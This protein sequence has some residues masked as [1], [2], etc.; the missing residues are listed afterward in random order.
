MTAATARRLA[1]CA[2]LASSLIAATAAAEPYLAVREGVLCSQCHVNRTGGGKRTA[3]G[4]IY[5]QTVMPHYKITVPEK[6]DGEEREPRGF[7]FD[8]HWGE[9]VSFGADLR[10][11]NLTTFAATTTWNDKPQTAPAGNTFKIPV[12][13]LFVEASL[14]KEHLVVYVDET[15]GPEGAALREGFAMYRELPLHGYVKAGRFLLPYGLRF[16]DDATFVRDM[17]GFNYANQD[18]GV[19]IGAEPGAAFVHVSLTNGTQG[20][21]DT[22]ISKQVTATA[23]ALFRP[24][25]F[26][27]LYSYADGSTDKSSTVRHV[28]GAYAALG[29]GRLAILGEADLMR[30]YSGPGPASPP[31]SLPGKVTW[32]LAAY[33]EVDLLVYRG[34]NVRVAYDYQDPFFTLASNGQRSRLTVGTEVFPIP[35]LG[36][37]VFYYMRRDVPQHVTENQDQLIVQIHGFL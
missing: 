31:G 33:G 25:R 15:V 17:T 34:V 29:I 8:P 32:Q 16:P 26:A 24:F 10:F 3:F 1:A 14:F 12:A 11:Q 35:F 27:L 4:V 7:F 22:N 20:G 36:V 37:G 30:D 21:T 23:G 5:S 6:R 2:A 18:L 9:H 28:G 13:N 19:E